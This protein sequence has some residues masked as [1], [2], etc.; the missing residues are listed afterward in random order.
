[1][2]AVLERTHTG[3]QPAWSATN[4]RWLTQ[5]FA[6]WSEQLARLDAERERR[7]PDL[8]VKRTLPFRR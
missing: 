4:Q 5:R 8:L 7:P 2:T 1:M 3:A 6:F